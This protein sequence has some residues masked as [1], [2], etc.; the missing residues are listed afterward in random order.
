MRIVGW[1]LNHRI[2]AKPIPPEAV[3]A[4]QHLAPDVLVLTEYVDTVDRCGFKQALRNMGLP[5]ISVSEKRDRHNQVLI[6]SR[7]EH[8]ASTVP[9]PKESH[10][11]TNFLAVSFGDR[12]FTLIGIRAPA[13]ESTK[14]LRSYWEDLTGILETVSAQKVVVVGDLNGDPE[15]P[16]S[17]GGRHMKLLRDK[18][19]KLPVP[20]GEWSYMSSDGRYTSRI[21][22]VLASPSVEAVSASYVS[23]V[24]GRIV[25]G[26]KETDPVSDHALIVCEVKLDPALE[27]EV[28]VKVAAEG[29]SITLYGVRAPEGWMFSRD[30]MD[31]TPEML[32]E[33]WT[34]HSSPRVK[35]WADA[36]RLL[37]Q[38]PWHRLYPR[39]VHGEFRK[40]VLE[41]VEE[42]Y[43]QEGSTQMSRLSEWKAL[44]EFSG[45]D[46]KS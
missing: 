13:Y 28:I 8:G 36:L 27:N 44:C 9:T 29:G 43:R 14:E 16:Q 37:D 32:D 25:A 30:V 33:P 18:G 7:I 15:L 23:K 22:H 26:P 20:T 35:S 38:Y 11:L 42:R 31:Q 4:I 6:A 2:Q 21:D 46:G 10:G 24:N 40:T 17:I 5:H 45:K 39:V 34:E 1:N 3:Q 41:A 12:D 19:W